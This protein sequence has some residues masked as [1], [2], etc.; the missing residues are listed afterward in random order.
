MSPPS[1]LP[2]S[3]NTV[4]K[5]YI[6]FHP[7]PTQCLGLILLIGNCLPLNYSFLQ[8]KLSDLEMNDT[9]KFKNKFSGDFFSQISTQSV[10]DM[11]FWRVLWVP[12]FP[13]TL[14]AEVWKVS[15]V[16]LRFAC[17][18]SRLSRVGLFATPWTVA[19]RAP[20]SMGFSRQEYWN[21]LP[22]PPPGDLP[23]PGIEPA[24]LGLQVDSSPAKPPGKPI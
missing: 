2:S 6:L 17:L 12:Q 19:C 1:P 14:L 15:P 22:R 21:R 24:S 4:N 10:M 5:S 11:G 7:Q 18:L 8:N 16:P 13:W 9:K 23:D 3:I 20:L